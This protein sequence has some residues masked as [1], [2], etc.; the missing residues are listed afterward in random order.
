MSSGRTIVGSA[1]FF[2]LAIQR[3]SSDCFAEREVCHADGAVAYN[4]GMSRAFAVNSCLIIA[5]KSGSDMLRGSTPSLRKRS[6]TSGEATAALISLLRRAM[7]SLG[8]LAPTSAPIQ[9]L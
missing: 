6:R 5:S 4:R 1:D 2:G 9:K 3:L 7:M 8:V